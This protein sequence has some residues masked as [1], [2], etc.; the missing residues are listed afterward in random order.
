MDIE[1]DWPQIKQLFKQAFRSSF[2]YSIASISEQGEP[3]LTPIGSVI[4]GNVGQGY[5]FEKF[6]Q[7]L[8]RNLKEHERICVLAVNSSP[9]YWIKSLCRGEFGTYPAIRLYGTAG[10]LRKATETEK[11]RWHK[12]VRRLRFT[13]GYKLL[14]QN[15][16]MIR[17]LH[18]D[19]VEPIRV[20]R[21]TQTLSRS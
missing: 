19:R 11:A 18:F 2:H 8:P 4:L 10:V 13:R 14:W 17:E 21:M 15:M 9:W 1:T 6:T 16:E 20:G 12:R 3:H 7:Q 5:Y